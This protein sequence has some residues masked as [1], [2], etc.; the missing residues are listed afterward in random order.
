MKTATR[1]QMRALDARTISEAGIPG[2]T[3]MERAGA[4]VARVVCRLTEQAGW[5]P[6]CLLVAGKGA[7]GG[8][9]LVAARH[10]KAAGFDV[11][12]VSTCET[13]AWTGDARIHLG[14]MTAAGIAVTER[15]AAE[16]WGRPFDD[17]FESMAPCVVVDGIL[18]TGLAGAARGVSARAIER[19]NEAG[20]CRP[21]VAID[22]PSGLDADTGMAAGPAVRADATVTMGYP[23]RGFI[24]QTAL[25]YVGTVDVVD[26][27]IPAAYANA[28]PTDMEM[29][30]ASDMA[31]LICPLPRQAHK[32]SRGHTLII[33]G[34]RGFAGA[35]ALAA[36][37]ALRSGAGLVTVLTPRSVAPIVAGL[38]PE[39]MVHC[40]EETEAGRLAQDAGRDWTRNVKDFDAVLIG[41]GLGVGADALAWVERVLDQS[42]TPAILDADALSVCAGRLE[43]IR[44]ACCPVTITPH[45]GEMARLT[46]STAQAVQADRVGTARRMAHELRCMTVLKGAGTIVCEPDSHPHVNMTGNPGMACGGSGDVLAGLLAGLLAQGCRP[47]DAARLAVYTHGRAGDI[48]AGR[49]SQAGMTAADLVDAIPCAWKAIRGR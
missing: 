5:A 20:R 26:I 38:A 37:A 2:E 14:K 47:F 9:A 1:A 13:S 7:N 45:P 24:E 32:G 39:A 8:D 16:D 18:G 28:L 31:D 22:I 34:S 15:P 10:L 6:R 30:S 49:R 35:A 40:G 21:V 44:Q 25:D 19:V 4:G 41:P 12:V 33:A 36:R 29:I 48:A 17:D 42:A 27:G 3:L 43:T 46:G 11:A 23:K